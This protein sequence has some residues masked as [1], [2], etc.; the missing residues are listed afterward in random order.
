M[1]SWTSVIQICACALSNQ[2]AK[3]SKVGKSFSSYK[4]NTFQLIKTYK[5]LG[6]YS[7]YDT[8]LLLASLGQ[9]P[10]RGF[11]ISCRA[12]PGA[13][14]LCLCLQEDTSDCK[15]FPLGMLKQV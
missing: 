8:D 12:L 1:C 5:G 14:S 4:F 10:F 9:V 15:S 2:W 11:Q 13:L 7:E 6:R 3:R